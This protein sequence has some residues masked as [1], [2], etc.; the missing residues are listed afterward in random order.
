MEENEISEE[1]KTNGKK[2]KAVKIAVIALIVFIVIIL[3]ALVVAVSVFVNYYNKFTDPDAPEILENTGTYVADI[4][5]PI[6]I[7]DGTV[8]PSD[9]LAEEDEIH[10]GLIEDPP[11]VDTSD[12]NTPPDNSGSSGGNSSGGNSSGGG[13]SGGGTYKPPAYDHLTTN[14]EGKIPIYKENPKSAD[15]VNIVVIGRDA[16]SYYGRADSAMVVSYNKKTSK[17][18][19]ISLLRDCYVP[20]EG[21]YSNKLGHALAYGGIGLYINTVNEILDLDI[22]HYII[23]DFAG[24]QSSVDQL[25][26]I[27]VTLTQKEV[28]Y[29]KRSGYNF[30]VGV[31]HMNGEQALWHCRN[32]SLAGADF[33]RTRRQRDV[34]MAIYQKA[35]SLGLTECTEVANTVS[36]YLKMNIPLTTCI[37]IIANVFSAGGITM[38]SAAMPFDGTWS[39]GYAKPPNYTGSMAVVKID[40]RANREKVN[41]FI[42][43][44]YNP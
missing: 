20:I 22:Q 37:E 39:Y 32:R 35:F 29:Y 43:G 18:K 1:I 36:K 10:G 26:G 6:G 19:V 12:E 41:K 15:I 23:M 44:Y 34:I 25:G 28:D 9:T 38:D 17:V 2:K 13:N 27:E 42:Y 40:I 16:D 24:V 4:D 30:K 8:D 33:E 3:L 11:A 14:Y 21:H 5:N 31:N 7:I